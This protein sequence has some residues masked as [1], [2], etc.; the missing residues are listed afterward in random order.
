MIG[1]SLIIQIEVAI[2]DRP[3]IDGHEGNDIPEIGSKEIIAERVLVNLDY[4]LVYCAR[5]QHPLQCS[6]QHIH[7][8]E[9]F[10][11]LRSFRALRESLSLPAMASFIDEP[12]PPASQRA[13]DESDLDPAAFLKSV[14]ELSEKRER[15][16]SE[17]LRKLEEEI[18]KGK[19]DRAARRA[20]KLADFYCLG[21][22][23]M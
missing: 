19:Q 17:R 2:K 16:D 1:W 20:G 6:I 3:Q 15:E 4:L 5:N 14:R 8:F 18:E 13:A 7:S 11:L 9:T 23:G 12:P 10:L 21:G 22:V